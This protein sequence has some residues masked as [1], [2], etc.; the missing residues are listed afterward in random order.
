VD[1]AAAR[2]RG[3]P[4]STVPEY[5]TPAVAQHTW[6]L[7]LELTQHVG[8]HSTSV[9]EGR[10]TSSRDWCY[11]ERSPIELS[12]LQLGVVGSGRIGGA[13]GRIGE[14]FGMKVAWARRSDGAAEL[15]A[16][17]Q[18]SDV[19]SLHCPL[20]PETRE[21]IRAET[22]AWL[23]PTALLINTSRGALIQEADLA[24]ALNESRIAGAA[25]D[26]LSTEPP[27][28]ENPLLSARNCL[29]TPHMAWA[30]RATRARLQ[31]VVAGN[32]RAFLAGQPIHVV[33]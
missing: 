2:A 23:K 21:L 8:L 15:Q 24:G 18:A 11:W 31:E 29:I 32:L 13:V 4:G 7:L 9:R 20:T 1:T 6:A 33:N 25:L 14:A 19:I 16:M 27:P 5:G 28:K 17:F 3:I 22:L 30:P 26:V 10:W 12:G